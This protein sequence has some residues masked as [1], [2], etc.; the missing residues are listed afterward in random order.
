MPHAYVWALANP[1]DLKEAEREIATVLRNALRVSDPARHDVHISESSGWLAYADR[2]RLWQTSLA[3]LPPTAAEARRVAE[4]F[5]RG[6]GTA[7]RAIPALRGIFLLPPQLQPVEVVL[8]P[9]PDGDRWD[10]WLYRTQPLLPLDGRL[11]A[12]VFGSLIEVR[13]GDYGQ[14]ISYRSRFSPTTAERLTTDLVPLVR[15]D[16]HEHDHE[17]ANEPDHGNEHEHGRGD[18]QAEP[19]VVYVQ[20]GDGIPQHYVAPYYLV[21]HGHHMGLASASEWSLVVT[22]GLRQD[23]EGTRVTAVVEGGSGDYAFD[24]GAYPIDGVETGYR[25]LGAGSRDET[26]DP[27]GRSVTSS[28]IM[29]PSGAYVVL[30]NVRDQ[31]T[32]AF[33]HHQQ[34][35]YSSPFVSDRASAAAGPRE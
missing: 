5:L 35:V 26:R 19:T 13:I 23:E 32:G 29:L 14:I 16:G 20:E 28:S 1:A 18:D 25:G 34:S 31:R 8:V 7:A 21:S 3:V 27:A 22:L 12:P 24:W 10:H 33:K 30:V 15:D 9:H 4:T 17:H 2:T 11:N 6:L